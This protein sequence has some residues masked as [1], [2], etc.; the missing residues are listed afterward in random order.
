MRMR[1]RERPPSR[2]A[3]PCVVSTNLRGLAVVEVSL[4][5][6]LRELAGAMIIVTEL[7]IAEGTS[8]ASASSAAVGIS[9]TT[10]PRGE[11]EVTPS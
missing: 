11:N 4:I 8:T 7:V 6:A 10:A 1:S 2:E 5:A 9:L 3:A